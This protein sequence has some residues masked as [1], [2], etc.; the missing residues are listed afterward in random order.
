MAKL[1]PIPLTISL[2]ER[3]KQLDGWSLAVGRF[4]IAFTSCEF[5]THLYI[6]TFGSERLHDAAA[7]MNLAPR[8]NL[9]YALVS[10]IGLVKQV[11]AR[12][13]AAFAKLRKLSVPR[14]VI[15]HNAPM[16]HIYRDSGS[17]KIEVR[18]ELRSARDPSKGITIAELDEWHAGAVQLDEEL[19]ILYGLV[20]QPQ[21][22][23]KNAE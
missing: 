20:R 15:A 4:L 10:D 9:A 17:G 19:A 22:R 14:N 12:V 21:S 1:E 3:A 2:E 23:S 16:M 18:H 6:K 5:W 11:Q 7:K 13:D 8:A